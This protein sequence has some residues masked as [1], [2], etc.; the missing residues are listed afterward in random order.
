MGQYSGMSNEAGSPHPRRRQLPITKKSAVPASSASAVYGLQSATTVAAALIR[1]PGGG[2][3]R[4]AGDHA[5]VDGLGDE[6]TSG[7]GV[8]PEEHE[9]DRGGGHRQ[10]V[11]DRHGA[12]ATPKR[13]IRGRDR[14]PEG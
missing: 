11:G 8:E 4:K 12:H 5:L 7:C 1:S 3:V 14:C 6:A 9:A 13:P 10:P 2:G